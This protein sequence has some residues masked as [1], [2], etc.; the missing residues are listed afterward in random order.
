[1]SLINRTG[2]QKEGDTK[3]TRYYSKRQEDAVAK[4]LGGSRTKNSGATFSEKG[5][6]LTDQFLL[7]CKVKTT[8]S[9]TMTVHK[10]WITKNAKEALFMGKP[11]SA[12][13]FSF[14]PDEENYYIINDELFEVL[15]DA[16]NNK[17]SNT[18]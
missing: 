11:Y 2:R 17:D 3:P 4:K 5:D 10:D 15:I 8:H 9:E 1:M 14:G 18:P 6:V 16:L 12:V 7:E 13:V